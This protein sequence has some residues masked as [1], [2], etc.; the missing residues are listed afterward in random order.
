MLAFLG[1]LFSV[2]LFYGIDLIFGS[3][4][5]FI[6]VTY[7]GGLSTLLVAFVGGLYTWIFWDHP[8][9]MVVVVTE[10][11]FVYWLHR[12]LGKS[13]LLADSL[14]WLFIGVPM[15]ILFYS[16][17]LTLSLEAS[18]L[19]ALKQCINGIFN[20]VIAGLMLFLLDLARNRTS[21][22][23]LASG[24]IKN[25][26]FQAML[27]LTIAAGTVPIILYGSIERQN[28][29]DL[30]IA[31]LSEYLNHFVADFSASQKSESD[32]LVGFNVHE[33]SDN[34]MAFAILDDSGKVLAS[35]GAP[36]IRSGRTQPGS[37]LTDGLR[38]LEPDSNLPIMQSW[39]Y[40]V[41][42]FSLVFSYP[43]F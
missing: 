5:V 3:V 26:L 16:Q 37:T 34:G 19:V 10:A 17:M 1:N 38:L 18:A 35:K 40:W 39:R 4:F 9:A 36:W 8:Y 12:R 7:I 22:V 33:R 32:F 30:L 25:I 11:A 6:A 14:F 21:P 13:L 41:A 28:R 23:Y 31:D 29:E 42:Y 20:V 27:A 43:G 15:V 24:Q 2:N